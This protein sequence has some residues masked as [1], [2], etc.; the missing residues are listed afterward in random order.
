M[1]PIAITTPCANLPRRGTREYSTSM[2]SGSFIAK[3]RRR[4]K[5]LR[6]K[7]RKI[8]NGEEKGF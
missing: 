6:N 5:E 4:S 3:S 8:E 7:Q 2:T 1:R